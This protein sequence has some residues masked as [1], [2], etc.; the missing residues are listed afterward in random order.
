LED[1]RQPGRSS[2]IRNEVRN[3]SLG[4]YSKVPIVALKP[5]GEPTSEIDLVN[6]SVN[7]ACDLYGDTPVAEF[8]PLAVKAVRQKMIEKSRARTTINQHVARLAKM[9]RWGVENELVSGVCDSND[10]S[11]CE[12]LV[13]AYAINGTNPGETIVQ[14][15]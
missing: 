10:S 7:V 5:N 11:K 4:G 14:L 8:G 3:E 15:P 6:I 13:A 2:D 1:E 9:F 12:G